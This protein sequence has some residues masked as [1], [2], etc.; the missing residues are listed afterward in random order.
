ME[1]RMPQNDLSHVVGL[2]SAPLLEGTIPQMLA[3]TAAAVP[4]REAAVF[5]S[6]GIRWSYAQFAAQ[7]DLLAGGLMQM[8]VARDRK[9]VV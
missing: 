9:S 6:E 5:V 7:V 4:N 8:G 2:T 1:N 3:Q